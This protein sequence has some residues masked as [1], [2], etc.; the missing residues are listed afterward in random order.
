MEKHHGCD[1]L[2]GMAC[3]SPGAFSRRR[4]LGVT[5]GVVGPLFLPVIRNP[6]FAGLAEEIAQITPFK[7]C[8][9][10]A[11][12]VPRVMAAGYYGPRCDLPPDDEKQ[13]ELDP[14][15]VRYLGQLREAAKALNLKLDIAPAPL[16]TPEDARRWAAQVEKEQPDGIVVIRLSILRGPLS[17]VQSILLGL[18]A[19]MLFFVPNQKMFGWGSGGLREELT[20]PGRLLCATQDFGYVVSR[21]NHLA[22]RARL[23]EMRFVNVTGNAREE[24]RL[25]FWGSR[26]L[27]VPLSLW[28]EQFI[29][30]KVKINAEVKAIADY[31][32]RT[33][34]RIA[35]P[36]PEAVLDGALCCLA[37]R[38]ILEQEQADA[39][40]MDCSAAAVGRAMPHSASPC[41]AFSRMMDDG[42][43]AICEQDLTCGVC[44]A[45]SQLLFGRPG[46][47]HNI[48]WDTSCADGGCFVAVHCTG[49]TRLRGTSEEPGPFELRFHH[50]LKDPM[51]MAVWTKGQQV[52][53]IKAARDKPVMS[54]VTG[55]VVGMLNPLFP[56]RQG[57]SCTQQVKWKP[58]GDY[59]VLKHPDIGGHHHLLLLGN[60]KKELLDFCQLFKIT[61]AGAV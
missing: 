30:E 12:C 33:A 15:Y 48:G 45:L 4:L 10:G 14:N 1:T 6:I 60:W 38:N 53:C 11:A 50:G 57:G 44:M 2:H 28:H 23:R 55:N 9:P 56:R 43:P 20:R 25:P 26:V 31:Y 36:S 34:Q 41:L 32:L 39:F 46:F 3:Y 5:A 49:P 19:P 51:A 58:D 40:T 35:G 22:A 18:D 17:E 16:N 7:P 29:Q 21:L 59:D 54:I 42:V 27:R 61:A 13:R 24:S 8:G 37:A 47:M 52:T